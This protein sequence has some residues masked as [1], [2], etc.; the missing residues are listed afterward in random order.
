MAD[1]DRLILG[2]VQF[3][4]AYG[5]NNRRGQVDAAEVANMLDYAHAQ[6][7][8]TLDTADAYGSAAARIGDFHRRDDRRFDIITKFKG[9]ANGAAI[10]D[11]LRTSLQTLH[12]PKAAGYL[13]HSPELFVQQPESL[14]HLITLRDA[15][16]IEHIGVSIY[17]NAQ[18]KAAIEHPE[19]GLIQLPYNL[20]DNHTRRGDLIRKAK[21]AGKLIH[22]RSVFLQGLF[23]KKPGK[24]PQQLLDLREALITLREIAA[25][26][27]LTTAQLCLGYVLHNA[28]IDGVLIGVDS[29]AQLKANLEAVRAPLPAGVITDVEQIVV[30]NPALLNPSNWS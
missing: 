8:R 26:Y 11:R 25:G 18:L 7:I 30:S 23:F 21:A 20:L 15:G 1:A 28:D 9:D 10:E 4:L 17:T 22:A 19:I 3:G 12:V 16:L 6:G 29:L 13:Y 24:L 27:R 5:I 2:T 14:T